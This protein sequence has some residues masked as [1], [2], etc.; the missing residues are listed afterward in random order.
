MCQAVTDRQRWPE[1]RPTPGVKSMFLARVGPSSTRPTASSATA[2]S[3]G[4]RWRAIH[5]RSFRSREARRDGRRFR[6]P[7]SP[8][9][10]H[11]RDRRS[12]IERRLNRSDTSK[13][14]NLFR[15]LSTG[16]PAE[17]GAHLSDAEQSALCR[18][19]PA[20]AG[21]CTTVSI[22]RSSLPISGRRCRPALPRTPRGSVAR[23][24]AANARPSPARS[25]TRPATG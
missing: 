5:D 24:T 14:R 3:S 13:R 4:L 18:P 19:H 9:E 8:G 22:R 23:E 17:R 6:Q 7:L 2:T 15:Q 1:G 10:R 25:S 16:E 12:G 11:H 20:Q 21:W